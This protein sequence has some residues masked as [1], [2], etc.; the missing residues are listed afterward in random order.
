MPRESRAHPGLAEAKDLINRVKADTDVTYDEIADT[1]KISKKNTYDLFSRRDIVRHI[2][3]GDLIVLCRRR[4]NPNARE[5]VR[6]VLKPLLD[7][8][9]LSPHE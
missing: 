2:R 4:S 1:L 6:K 8:L 9:E 5:F 3:L 7:E